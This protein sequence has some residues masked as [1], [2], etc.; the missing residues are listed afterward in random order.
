MEFIHIINAEDGRASEIYTAYTQ[1][2]PHDERRNERQFYTLF[3]NPKVK[4]F[5]V[6]E[7]NDRVGYLILWHFENFYFIEHL[8]VF[9]E[10]RNQNL[11]SII[12]KEL[13]KRHPHLILETEPDSYGEKAEKRIR[14]YQK[15]GFSLIDKNYIQ[16]AYEQDKNALNLYLMSNFS[17]N[18]I[19]NLIKD[20]HK[21]VYQDSF[22]QL[23]E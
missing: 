21:T 12:L 2:F 6:Q 5:I 17:V 3:K 14:F 11:G 15:N 19:K 1:A 10:F 16:P 23:L 7:N 4:I 18:D 13:A 8:E 9:P 20:I 22:G